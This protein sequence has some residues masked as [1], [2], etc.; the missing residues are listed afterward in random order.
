MACC[1]LHNFLRRNCAHT[2]N[3]VFDVEDSIAGTIT[4]GLQTDSGNL[5]NFQNSYNRNHT[6]EAKKVKNQFK[7]YF[8]NSGKVDWQHAMV[9]N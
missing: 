2:S 7:I 8:N 1:A 4:P 5:L 3:D 6:T 9:S